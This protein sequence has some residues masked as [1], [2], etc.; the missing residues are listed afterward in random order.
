MEGDLVSRA[1]VTYCRI[2]QSTPSAWR[3]T[4]SED[5]NSPYCAI[6]I[7]SLRM[8]GDRQATAAPRQQRNFNPLPPHG[9]RPTFTGEN[10][11]SGQHFNPL[12][13][14]GGRQ[15][16]RCSGRCRKAISIHS[17][18]MEGDIDMLIFQHII[19]AFQS[20]PSAWRETQ[21]AGR[22]CHDHSTFQSTPSAWRETYLLLLYLI[23]KLHFNPLPPHGGRHLIGKE[24]DR[25]RNFNPLPPHGGRHCQATNGLLPKIISIHSLR[26]EGD[27]GF[28]NPGERICNFNPLPPHGGRR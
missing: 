10:V 23:V 11:F 16:C 19:V 15:I 4:P 26:M 2:F 24:K 5:R 27:S 1:I 20:T 3:E 13:P 8:E 9:G 18:R 17:L 14:H 21:N 6:S 25:Q 28:S 12:P 22:Q 7:H